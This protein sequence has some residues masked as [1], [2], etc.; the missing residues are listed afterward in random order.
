M[1]QA[2]EEKV[3]YDML[4]NVHEALGFTSNNKR[5]HISKRACCG[6]SR[7]DANGARVAALCLE[8]PFNKFVE[9]E[10]G[11][12]GYTPY[13]TPFLITAWPRHVRA[14]IF[15]CRSCLA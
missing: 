7:D 2:F 10:R 4:V 8:N 15:L 12:P 3:D 14:T 6:Y 13:S 11:V 9:D 5:I 1:T